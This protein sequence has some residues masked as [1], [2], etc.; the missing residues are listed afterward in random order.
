MLEPPVGTISF[1]QMLNVTFQCL[2]NSNGPTWWT[3]H[4]LDTDQYLSTRDENDKTKFEERGIHYYSGDTDANITIPSIVENNRT[5]IRCATFH[6][7]VT[8][9]SGQIKLIIAGKFVII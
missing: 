3:I 2:V 8:E 7:G 1:N 6:V 9:F 4:Y 5:L